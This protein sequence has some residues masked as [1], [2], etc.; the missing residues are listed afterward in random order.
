MKN[1]FYVPRTKYELVKWF[2]KNKPNFKVSRFS[3]NRLLAIYFGVRS[4]ERFENMKEMR[5][6]TAYKLMFDLGEIK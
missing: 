6:A 2:K 4:S 3:K 5:D 1:D